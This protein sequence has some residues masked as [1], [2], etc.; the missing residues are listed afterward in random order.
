MSI[1]PCKARTC[2]LAI[3]LA[4]LEADVAFQRG[5]LT[6]D[7]ANRTCLLALALLD[8][9][10][11]R[12]PPLA[13]L[14]RLTATGFAA[15]AFMIFSTANQQIAPCV[16]GDCPIGNQGTAL[17]TGVAPAVQL[18]DAGAER[19][20]GGLDA[21]LLSLLPLLALGNQPMMDKT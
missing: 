12:L 19:T 4:G 18:Q 20:A 2:R 17:D 9:A 5:D 11:G 7:L 3:L 14:A 10:E 1:S 16:N 8:A 13:N 21:V 15:G 6:T